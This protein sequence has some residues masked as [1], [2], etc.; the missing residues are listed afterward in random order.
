MTPST[1]EPKPVRQQNNLLR[2]ELGGTPQGLPLYRWVFSEDVLL[3]QP[4]LLFQ[5]GQPI[6]DYLCRC[7]TNVRVH[8]AAC[9]LSVPTPRWERRRIC[10]QEKD[11]WIFCKWLPPPARS[12]WDTTLPGV[13]YPSEGYYAPVGDAAKTIALVSGTLPF[14]E[15]TAMLIKCVRDMRDKSTRQILREMDTGMEKKEKDSRNQLEDQVRDSLTFNLG[16][17]GEKGEHSFGGVPSIPSPILRRTSKP[18]QTAGDE[19]KSNASN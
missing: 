18:T 6:Y 17:P 2:R 9:K 4:M 14:P 10:H 16:V 8:S 15:T 19:P 11:Q 1:L 13:P 7:G 12:A 3:T 5:D